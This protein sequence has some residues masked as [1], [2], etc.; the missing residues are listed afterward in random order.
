MFSSEGQVPVAATK[1]KSVRTL[2]L[3]LVQHD[4]III[5]GLKGFPICIPMLRFNRLRPRP[6]P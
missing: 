2:V 6:F 1:A 4:R 5:L 3:T